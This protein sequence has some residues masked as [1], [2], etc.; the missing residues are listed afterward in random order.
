MRAKKFDWLEAV[1]GP[2]SFLTEQ[3]CDTA[4]SGARWSMER[5]EG[6]GGSGARSRKGGGQK[7]VGNGGIRG[8]GRGRASEWAKSRGRRTGQRGSS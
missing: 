1:P 6:P 3:H 4:H 8:E 5:G 7:T 2:E